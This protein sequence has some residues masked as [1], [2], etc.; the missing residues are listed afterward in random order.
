MGHLLR[1]YDYCLKMW[2]RKGER[3]GGIPGQG[4]GDIQEPRSRKCFWKLAWEVEAMI[5]LK[6]RLEGIMGQMTEGLV[7]YGKRLET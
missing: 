1:D 3:L 5:C 4:A 7:H 6:M 2:L